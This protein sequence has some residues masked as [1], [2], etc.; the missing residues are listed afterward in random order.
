MTGWELDRGGGKRPR[1]KSPVGKRQGEN[2]RGKPPDT[3]VDTVSSLPSDRRLTLADNTRQKRRTGDK[4]ARW[5][6][7][8]S[9]LQGTAFPERASS[10]FE[11]SFPRYRVNTDQAGLSTAR[12]INIIHIFLWMER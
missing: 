8:S 4:S 10:I 1:G 7:T 3:P 6:R 9:R 11:L 5:T 2:A 12:P